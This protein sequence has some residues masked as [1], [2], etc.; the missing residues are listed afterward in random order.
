MRLKKSHIQGF[1]I[2]EVIISTVIL[3]ILLA[4]TT[5]LLG[6]TQ[7]LAYRQI[8]SGDVD[9]DARLALLRIGE[10]ASQAAYIYPASQALTVPGGTT[11]TTGA[12]ALALLVPAGTPYCPVATGVTTS[13]Q[14][15]AFIYRTL[16]RSTLVATLGAQPRNNSGS[17]LVEDRIQGVTWNSPSDASSTTLPTAA[18]TNFNT[19][20]AANVTQ[21]VIADSVSTTTGD[22]T[23]AT[24]QVS[25][26]GSSYDKSFATSPT[27][28]NTNANALIQ[29][30]QPQITL[31]YTNG[32]SVKRSTF[33]YARSVPRGAPPGTGVQ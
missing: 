23:F 3:G 1:T 21:G 19:Y 32:I 22:T 31:A 2:I 27:T 33:I 8:N 7:Q 25:S 18:L 13:S 9:Q 5:A 16:A 17:V 12:R 29:A 20:P 24:L 30:V 14:Y 10:V 26:T 11:V 4:I 28:A 6:S 15:C